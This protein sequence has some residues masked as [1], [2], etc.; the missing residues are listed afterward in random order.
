MYTTVF[1]SH[2]R[3]GFFQVIGNDELRTFC[4]STLFNGFNSDNALP[5]LVRVRMA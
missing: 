5:I 1:F 2:G 4:S 3:T